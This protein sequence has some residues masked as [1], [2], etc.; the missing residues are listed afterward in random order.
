MALLHKATLDPTKRALMTAW[1]ATRPWADGFDPVRTI[2]S[3]RFD[4]PAGEV[5]LEGALLVDDAGAVAHVPLSYRGAPLEGADPFLVG[6]AEH[7]VLGRRWVYDAC[8]DPIWVAALAAAIATGGGG[9]EQYFEVDGER[10]VVEPRMTVH[11]SGS[12][13]A[14]VPVTAA[15]DDVHDDG[16]TTVTRSGGVELV[17]VRMVGTTIAAEQTLSGRWGDASGVLAGLR[18]A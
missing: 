2:A 9:A 6:T 11:G 8:G 3:Y 16:A 18:P 1:L 7:S 13:D 4:D 12:P 15:I 10:V 5:G 14:A 17:V